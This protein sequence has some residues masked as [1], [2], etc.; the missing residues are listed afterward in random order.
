[1]KTLVL[2]RHAKSSWKFPELKDMDRPLK[3]RG[4]KD[5]PLIGKVLKDLHVAPDLILSSPAVR[6]ITTAKIMAKETGFDETKIVTESKIYLESKSKLLKVINQ[7]N[8]QHNTVFLIGHNPGLTDFANMLLSESVDD[9][10]TSGVIG[11]QFESDNWSEAEKG[12][13]KK[14]FYEIPKVHRKK[15]EKTEKQVL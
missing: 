4:L 14:T 12:K 15:V 11:I 10:P 8:D 1:M 7:I 6:A 9:L 5:A 2:I 3:K 13:G